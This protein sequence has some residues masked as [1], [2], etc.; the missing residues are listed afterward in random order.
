MSSF[1][2]AVLQLP[3]LPETFSRLSRCACT[4]LIPWPGAIGYRR[5]YQGILIRS[6]LTR[7]V[8]Y[9]T[10]VR[11]GDM[12]VTGLICY[13]I[14]ELEGVPVG[15]LALTGVCAEAVASKGMA[16]GAACW[17]TPTYPCLFSA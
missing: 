11:F 17:P 15:A 10:M 12:A 9:G 7:R 1:L 16:K 13:W 6:D 4:I 2:S 5:F 8:A 14:E 3:S